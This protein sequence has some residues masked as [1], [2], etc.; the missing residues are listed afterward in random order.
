MCY[1]LIPRYSGGSPAMVHDGQLARRIAKQEREA[2]QWCLEGIRGEEWKKLA[3]TQGLSGI[4]LERLSESRYRD[5]VTD[6]EFRDIPYGTIRNPNRI[7]TWKKGSNMRYFF[8]RKLVVTLTRSKDKDA[9]MTPVLRAMQ[10]QF[11][12]D[13]MSAEAWGLWR[14]RQE[15]Q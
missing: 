7:Y 5:M 2:Y 4:I 12:T 3:E 13:P 1:E 8:R 9:H 14:D 15:I 6:E 10:E 11:G